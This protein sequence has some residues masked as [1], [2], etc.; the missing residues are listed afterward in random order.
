MKIGYMSIPGATER[1][2]KQFWIIRRVCSYYGIEE[3]ILK[4]PTR[5]KEV[6]IP[7]QVAM[8][9]IKKYTH[10]GL[11]EVGTMFNRD[12]ATVLHAINAI[13]N[14][15]DTDKEY[16]ARIKQFITNTFQQM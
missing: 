3:I 8:Y 4:S 7:R 9:C 11:K 16:G 6:V 1:E 5:K 10:L 12:H 13:Q 2:D 15:M 14:L